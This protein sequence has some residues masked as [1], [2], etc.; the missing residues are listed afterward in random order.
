LGIYFSL[1]INHRIQTRPRPRHRPRRQRLT[2]PQ[3]P[4]VF[5]GSPRWCRGCAASPRPSTRYI[6]TSDP[7][8]AA[9]ES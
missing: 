5:A 7:Y 3:S 6:R 2:A 9:A 8:W 1:L 4:R